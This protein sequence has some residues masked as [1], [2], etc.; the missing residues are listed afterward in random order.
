MK[1][2]V[3]IRLNTDLNSQQAADRL[4]VAL[5]AFAWRLGDSD[6]QG[7]YVS[8]T[9]AAGVQVMMWLGEQPADLT[10]SFAGSNAPAPIR[11][12]LVNAVQDFARSVGEVVG[13]R[14]LE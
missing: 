5:P 6:A 4:A 2:F 12:L 1:D 14:G 10:V 9:D 11:A 13:V 8:G 3:R 7:P